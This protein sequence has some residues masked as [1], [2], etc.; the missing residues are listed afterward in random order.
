[1]FRGNLNSEGTGAFAVSLETCKAVYYKWIADNPSHPSFS[2]TIIPLMLS[3]DLKLID[4]EALTNLDGEIFRKIYRDMNYEPSFSTAINICAAMNLSLVAT[5]H[6]MLNAGFNILS[7]N[8][9]K[10]LYIISEM[11]GESLFTRNRVLIALGEKSLSK[12]I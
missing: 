2:E 12:N 1:M 7:D 3:R 4:F 11:Q 6:V 10:F 9:K 8:H 5:I